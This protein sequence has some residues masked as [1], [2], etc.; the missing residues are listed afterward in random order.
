[1]LDDDIK[2]YSD[3]KRHSFGFGLGYK[4]MNKSPIL[5]KIYIYIKKKD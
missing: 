3:S 5:P 1:M 4:M 2:R